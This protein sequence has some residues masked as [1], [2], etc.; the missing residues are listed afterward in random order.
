MAGKGCW[1]GGG[2]GGGVGVGVA[3]G[4]GGGGGGGPWNRHAVLAP[5]HHTYELLTS[6]CAAWSMVYLYRD[7][8]SG[9]TLLNF[10]RV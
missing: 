2:G 7:A 3:P 9:S 6:H 1:S 10:R 4:G 5:N 8:G